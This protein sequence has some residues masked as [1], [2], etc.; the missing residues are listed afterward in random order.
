MGEVGGGRVGRED[1]EGGEG[2]GGRM[3]RVGYGLDGGLCRVAEGL[4][5]GG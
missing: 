3:G 4:R 1:G 5:S 2:G